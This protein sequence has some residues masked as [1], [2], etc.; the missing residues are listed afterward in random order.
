MQN[1]LALGMVGVYKTD[2]PQI[3]LDGEQC[4]A[5]GQLTSLIHGAVRTDTWKR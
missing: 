1:D 3:M 2:T 5:Y 4:L